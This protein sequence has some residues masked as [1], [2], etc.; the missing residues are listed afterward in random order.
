[1]SKRSINQKDYLSIYNVA[2]LPLFFHPFGHFYF[3]LN[4][5][6]SYLLFDFKDPDY[7]LEAI[8]R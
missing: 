8:V 5:K 7:S 3:M 1:M 6:Y 4:F 2:P